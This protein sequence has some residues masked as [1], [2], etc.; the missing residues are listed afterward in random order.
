[1]GAW[2]NFARNG[3]LRNGRLG[4]SM[5]PSRPLMASVTLLQLER[6]ARRSARP[7]LRPADEAVTR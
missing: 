7:G 5:T 6:E 2:H 4:N 1:M 3:R